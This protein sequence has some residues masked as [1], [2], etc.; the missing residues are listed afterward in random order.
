MCKRGAQYKY[1]NDRMVHLGLKLVSSQCGFVDKPPLTSGKNKADGMEMAIHNKL[2]LP[3]AELFC[4]IKGQ[5]RT[6]VIYE[7]AVANIV[8]IYRVVAA[9]GPESNRYTPEPGPA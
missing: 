2:Q 5:S 8:S 6:V 1:H 3:N 9:S 7:D 4:I